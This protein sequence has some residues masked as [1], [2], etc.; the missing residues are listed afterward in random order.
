MH[1]GNDSRSAER[2]P[3][4]CTQRP[5]TPVYYSLLSAGQELIAPRPET[6]CATSVV[7]KVLVFWF[8]TG[9]RFPKKEQDV[10]VLFMST[11]VTDAHNRFSFFHDFFEKS[12]QKKQFRIFFQFSSLLPILQENE[13]QKI[14]SKIGKKTLNDSLQSRPITALSFFFLKRRGSISVCVSWYE[15]LTLMFIVCFIACVYHFRLHEAFV[16]YQAIKPSG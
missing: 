11:G 5:S 15:S 2:F 9:N 10:A 4:T 3:L 13:V 1:G 7:T 14:L 16:S 8:G 12:K 6:W